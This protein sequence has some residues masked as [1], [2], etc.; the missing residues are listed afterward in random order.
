MTLL[1]QKA[2]LLLFQKKNTNLSKWIFP[3]QYQTSLYQIILLCFFFTWRRLALIKLKPI[4]KLQKAN[5]LPI[6]TANKINEKAC[7]ELAEIISEIVKDKVLYFINL[8]WFSAISGMPAKQEKPTK[9]KN[10]SF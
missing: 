4:V 8:T 10:W 6:M 1:L 9:K 3:A 5:G 2:P 7:A